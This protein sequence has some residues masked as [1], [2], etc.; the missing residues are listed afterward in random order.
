MSV[1]DN[2]ITLPTQNV[3]RRGRV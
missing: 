3:L 2:V 1:P